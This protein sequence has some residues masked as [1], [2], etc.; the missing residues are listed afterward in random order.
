MK[1]LVTGATGFLG[2]RLIEK[3]HNLKY[4]NEIVATGR[5]IRKHIL[6]KAIKLIIS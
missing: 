1:I 5:K 2:F 6:L 4:V 3:L